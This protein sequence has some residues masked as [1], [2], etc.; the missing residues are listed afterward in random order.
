MMMENLAEECYHRKSGIRIGSH[1]GKCTEDEWLVG[2]YEARRD[3]RRGAGGGG[4]EL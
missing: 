4:E 2:D 3:V 1:D